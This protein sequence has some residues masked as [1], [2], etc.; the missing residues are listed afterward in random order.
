VHAS[1]VMVFRVAPKQLF[2][3]QFQYETSPGFGERSAN[4]DGC[5]TTQQ[6]RTLSYV[7]SMHW[8]ELTTSSG[9][10][11]EKKLS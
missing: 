11:S 8:N 3:K 1:E 7:S 4:R 2:P 6:T 10:F 5:A 9:P